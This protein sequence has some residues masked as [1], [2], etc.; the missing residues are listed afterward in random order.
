MK[1]SVTKDD[2]GGVYV[3]RDSI[4]SDYGGQGFNV[5][6]GGVLIHFEDEEDAAVMAEKVLIRLGKLAERT[7]D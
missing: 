5:W 3:D 7:K 1:I 4:R 6:V 2:C